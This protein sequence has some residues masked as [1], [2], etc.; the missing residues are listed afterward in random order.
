L[1]K[2]EGPSTNERDENFKSASKPKYQS[3]YKKDVKK[4]MFDRY[5]ESDKLEIVMNNKE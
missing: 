4:V 5:P 2:K 1:I 3:A